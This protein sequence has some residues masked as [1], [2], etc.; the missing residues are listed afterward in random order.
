VQTP[1]PVSDARRAARFTLTVLTL[2]NLFNY[3]DRYVAPA[4]FES[5]KHSELHPSDAQLGLLMTGFLLVYTLT[6]PV[7]GALGDTRSRPRLLA[8]G[9]ALWSV[10]TA[11]GGFARNYAQLFFAR[12]AVGVGE[13]A[14][15]SIGPS[16]LADHYPPARRGRA[17][18]TFFLAIPVGSALG[19][20]VGGLMDHQFGWR[21]A[22]L[23]AGLPGLL[24]ALLALRLRDVPRGGHDQTPPA[25]FP[26]W[27]VIGHL[28][29]NR[30][31]RLTV[32]G[33]AAYTFALGGIA[34]WVSP[35]LQRVR[36][37][38]QA[39]ATVRF[40]AIVVVTGLVGTWGGGWLADRLLART[41]QAYLWMSAVAT[42][43]AAPLLFL[44]LAAP[45]PRVYWSAM[46]AAQ[47][48][49]FASTGPI[50]SVIVNVVPAGIRATAV[51]GSIFAI[52]VLG[53]VPSPFL[54]GVVSDH[55][56][57]AAGVLI[58]PAAAL[59]GGLV[60]VRAARTTPASL[61]A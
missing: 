58:L 22:F 19:Y 28:L 21:R 51:A 24:L 25:A 29:A 40:G 10:A 27:A 61:P 48:L 49:M 13:A 41:R 4:V 54:V 5:I 6:A 43:A 32:L 45:D 20:M 26:G 2:I 57:L 53:D 59:V 56:S 30:A 17:F 35:F 60:W 14:Y 11:L 3:L 52:H 38:P 16:L 7:F 44:T 39:T 15:G 37:L 36:G 1:A 34:T 50:N 55:S 42:L 47:L 18:A 31:Y 12:G 46:V 33:Y 8:I 9:I 23:V